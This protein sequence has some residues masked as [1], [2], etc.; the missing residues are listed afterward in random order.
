MLEGWGMN[1]CFFNSFPLLKNGAE[2]FLYIKTVLPHPSYAQYNYDK[3]SSSIWNLIVLL[4]LLEALNM[5]HLQEIIPNIK[6]GGESLLLVRINAPQEKKTW[7][8]VVI[9]TENTP[10]ISCVPMG[11]LAFLCYL[12]TIRHG[13]KK[14]L[15]TIGLC[16]FLL[17]LSNTH[18]VCFNCALPIYFPPCFNI[19][20]I[21]VYLL[22]FQI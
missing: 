5:M 6:S 1:C 13:V 8:V 16:C 18:T 10:R 15:L 21:A 12:Y 17:I 9:S 2:F 20:C 7:Q 14:E 4:F 19:M 3:E 11:T 22:E